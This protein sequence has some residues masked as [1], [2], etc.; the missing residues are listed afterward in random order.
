M[1]DRNP[2]AGV[3]AK[4]AT[5]QHPQDEAVLSAI[6]TLIKTLAPA[7]REQLLSELKEE[8]NPISA[9]RAGDILGAVIRL[10]PK[11]QSWTIAH[12]KE[13][14]ATEGIEASAK[15]VYNAVGYLTRRKHVRRLGYGRYVVDGI[16]FTTID[17]LGGQPSITE[18]DHDD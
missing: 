14:I 13:S 15:E 3:F 1:A 18:G 5:S 6:R 9:P 8:L 10:L 17:E 2:S 7:V 11:N 16:A 4:A 12:L